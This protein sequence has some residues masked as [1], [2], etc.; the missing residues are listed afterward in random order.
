MRKVLF[1]LLI[2]ISFS[3]FAEKKKIVIISGRDSHGP[4]AHNWS[5][6]ADL[7]AKALNEQSGLDVKAEVHRIWPKDEKAFEGAA[8]VVILCDGGGGHVLMKHLDNFDKVMAK[9]IG[10]VNI[11]Y[12]VEVPKGKAGDYFLKWVGGYFETHWSVNPH[13]NG[14]FKDL[15]KHPITKGMA[16]F[17]LNDEWYYH[18]RFAEKGVIPILSALPP[19][20]TLKRNDG[21]HS[22]NPHVRAA[23]LERKEKQHV[24][25]AFERENGGRGFSTTGAHY[26]KNW[27]ND[28]FRTMVLNGILW[29]AKVDVP[30]SGTKSDKNPVKE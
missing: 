10:L 12:A 30:E 4:K 28:S 1:F 15:P 8:T 22:N 21:P 9:G 17:E 14:V 19:E 29:T 3:L 7:L 24:A 13:W 18:M 26:H 6:G 16:P 5:L 23:V 11:H 20:S 2:L 25:W 27:N